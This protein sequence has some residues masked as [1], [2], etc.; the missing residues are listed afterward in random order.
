M[1]TFM[2]IVIDAYLCSLRRSGRFQY[3]VL[4]WIRWYYY[5]FTGS[6][7]WK[8]LE[9]FR[10][11]WIFLEFYG[12]DDTLI[13][14][15][16]ELCMVWIRNNFK[17]TIWR[18]LTSIMTKW[19]NIEENLWQQNLV[20]HSYGCVSMQNVMQFTLRSDWHQFGCGWFYRYDL[21]FEK[22]HTLLC[23]RRQEHL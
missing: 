13:D 12:D 3:Q 23:R 7:G 9:I 14:A 6:S 18:S 10:K 21:F 5:L 8:F 17:R 22:F 15:D 2:L 20:S 4:I 11:R 1:N 19:L 16:C